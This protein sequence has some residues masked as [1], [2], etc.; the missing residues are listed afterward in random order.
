MCLDWNAKADPTSD[1]WVCSGSVMTVMAVVLSFRGLEDS[2][3]TSAFQQLR[4][5]YKACR[6]LPDGKQQ[7]RCRALGGTHSVGCVGRLEIC[8][9]SL[10]VNWLR[11]ELQM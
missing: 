10:M 6:D 4:F 3:K 11:R 2:S 7:V 5:T 9:R 1:V 8:G